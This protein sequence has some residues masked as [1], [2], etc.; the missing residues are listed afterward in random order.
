MELA[1]LAAFG[2][3]LFYGIGSLLQDISAKRSVAKTPG[4]AGARSIAR[5]TMS[6]PYLLGTAL[7]GVAWVLSLLALQRLPLFAVQAISAASIGIVV[8]GS[9]FVGSP[10]AGRFQWVLL[11]I[12]GAGLVA[13]AA[14]AQPERAAT[15]S[16]AFVVAMWV[17]VVTVSAVAWRLSSRG[18]GNGI[19]GVMGALSGVAFGGMSICARAMEADRGLVSMATDPLTGAL[20]LYGVIGLVV[21]A[22][23]LQRGTVTVALSTQYVTQTLLP[24]IIGLLVLGDRSRPGQAP[25]A[26]IGFVLATVAAIGLSM[27][28]PRGD[29]RTPV[30]PTGR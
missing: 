2:S 12:L 18:A 5:A 26:I 1:Y 24:A 15:V 10:R 17:G 19:A 3:A 13:L 14:T 23:A 30:E 27:V 22:G 25:V 20:L 4:V 6:L 8:V 7:D 29:R 28:S 9:P 16:T 21:F 11:A